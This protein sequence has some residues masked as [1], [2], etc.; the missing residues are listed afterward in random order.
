MW[1]VKAQILRRFGAQEHDTYRTICVS[2]FLWNLPILKY[3]WVYL[4]TVWLCAVCCVLQSYVLSVTFNES[5]QC[6]YILHNQKIFTILQD[7]SIRSSK[8]CT[9]KYLSI[10]V[11]VL[12]PIAPLSPTLFLYRY[13]FR[14]CP[15]TWMKLG[16]LWIAC[17]EMWWFCSLLNAIQWYKLNTYDSNTIL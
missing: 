13:Y 8:T 11:S 4:Y 14:L 12:P 9:L 10:N 5:K 3:I 7:I 17:Y 2:V 1:R 6:N 16:L 15:S